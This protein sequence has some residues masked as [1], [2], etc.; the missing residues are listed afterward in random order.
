MRWESSFTVSKR[1]PNFMA[2]PFTEKSILYLLKGQLSFFICNICVLFFFPWSSSESSLSHPDASS[3]NML[4]VNIF[5]WLVFSPLWSIFGK[6]KFL[7]LEKSIY[8]FTAFMDHASSIITKK[9]FSNSK[10]F[11]LC[12]LL[13]VLCVTFTFVINLIFVFDARHRLIFFLVFFWH[14]D[15]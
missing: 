15:I 9:S 5:K 10:D 2:I 14:V 13:E 3:S 8:H 12:F 11:L 7:I 6:Q 1:L 4:F